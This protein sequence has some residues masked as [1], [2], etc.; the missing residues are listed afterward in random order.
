MQGRAP[1]PDFPTRFLGLGQTLKQLTRNDP[2][3]GRGCA[4]KWC[5]ADPGPRQTPNARR[6]RICGGAAI[7]AFTR[8]FD[9]L[10]RRNRVR[11]TNQLALSRN[12]A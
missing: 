2:C 6:S 12:P 7:S 4:M 8:V 10:L 5:A 1:T 3:P 11:D 9:A